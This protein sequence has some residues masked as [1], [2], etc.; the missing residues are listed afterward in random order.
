MFASSAVIRIVQSG[1]FLCLCENEKAGRVG[2]T[3][4]GDEQTGCE[5]MQHG[6][7]L[8]EAAAAGAGVCSLWRNG[9]RERYTLAIQHCL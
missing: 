6:D 3:G 7:A 1:A 2:A 5:Q 9:E 4:F 8:K